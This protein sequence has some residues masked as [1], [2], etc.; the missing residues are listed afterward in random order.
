MLQPCS[1]L[2]VHCQPCVCAHTVQAAPVQASVRGHNSAPCVS[3]TSSRQKL[4]KADSAIKLPFAP[5]YSR[6][7]VLQLLLALESWDISW[8]FRELLVAKK[9]KAELQE[10]LA[11][12][13]LNSRLG[14]SSFSDEDAGSTS[15]EPEP[16]EKPPMIKP[17]FQRKNSIAQNWLE[18]SFNVHELIQVEEFAK[19]I[20]A[21]EATIP[22]IKE[23][24]AARMLETHGPRPGNIPPTVQFT[25]PIYYASENDPVMEITVIRIG[26]QEQRSV[27]HYE[28]VDGSAKAGCRY[29]AASGK[30]VYEKGE[31][32]K[33]ISVHI[34]QDDNWDATLEFGVVLKL[35]GIQGANLGRYLWNSRVLIID[36]DVFPTNRFE[37]EIRAEKVEEINQPRLLWEYFR[38]NFKNKVVRRGTIKCLVVDQIKNLY[39]ILRIFLNLYLID[40]ILA[41]DADEESLLLKNKERE[42]I[43]VMAFMVGPFF[44]VHFSD[45]SR[46]FW[47][48]GGVSR[49]TLQGNL[50]R[51]FLNYNEDARRA[52]KH[53]DLLMAITRDTPRLVK[54]GF[55]QLVPL[56]QNFTQL[57]LLLG[58]QIG[59]PMLQGKTLKTTPFIP[60]LAF[61]ILM[62]GFLKL[63]N[64]ETRRHLQDVD[65]EESI[66]LNHVDHTVLDFRLIADYH[67]KPFFM[68]LYEDLINDLNKKIVVATA[69]DLNNKNY[70]PWLSLI[71]MSGYTVYGGIQVANTT[72]SG[73][74]LGMFL[75]NLSVFKAIGT[76]WGNI[77]GKILVMQS[78]FPSLCHIVTFMNLPTEGPIRRSLN[79]RN[80]ELEELEMRDLSL[81]LPG[82]SLTSPDI[83]DSLGI[84]FRRLTYFY[85]AKGHQ[86]EI[87]GEVVESTVAFQQGGF[88]ALVGPQGEGKSTILKILGQVILPDP[89]SE[90]DGDLFVPSHLRVLHIS[91]E[92]LFFQG[93]LLTNLT[94]GVHEGDDDG[95]LERVLKICLRLGLPQQIQDCLHNDECKLHWDEVLSLTE[96]HL[97]S[98]ARALISNPEV[99]CIHKPTLPFDGSTSLLVLDMLKEFV[100]ER[101]VFM[102]RMTY[103]ER[104]PRTCIITASRVQALDM[105]DAVYHVN[106]ERGI[107]A[108]DQSCLN[109]EL[110]VDRNSFVTE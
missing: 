84:E 26:D 79:K 73:L 36:N 54:N 15:I 64:A 50:L 82:L 2:K 31:T 91:Q 89:A 63:R 65:K 99:L 78:T 47:K 1:Q 53:S 33:V 102:D 20:P 45:Y 5:R 4:L 52:V 76:S 38:M 42:L 81:K 23:K 110:K 30:L 93:S 25:M 16:P 12:L 62:L 35:E 95:K 37:T 60:M 32:H 27:V 67:R 22:Y 56:A 41:E 109:S 77:Y 88:Y 49:K 101:G 44:L 29:I 34:V 105:A 24:I 51:K 57:F 92:P 107:Q 68:S 3:R 98:I 97:L 61:P 100:E 28:T 75:A 90:S 14:K 40:F 94:F 39:F 46:V 104:R 66:L 85:N 18:R 48:V 19:H 80:V 74:T 103:H 83:V 108:L 72:T 21:G 96:R 69:G 55:C 7:E 70:A 11:T 86:G 58:Y 71:F 9:D 6:L 10:S 87:R 8:I 13:L 17:C 59:V 106:A 43:M